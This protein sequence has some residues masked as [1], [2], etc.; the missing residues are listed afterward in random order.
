MNPLNVETIPTPPSYHRWYEAVSVL[1]Q[2]SILMVRH[3]HFSQ[4]C[5]P[6]FMVASASPLLFS[7]WQ[8]PRVFG[9]Y[10][11]HSPTIGIYSQ[12]Y[13]YIYTYIC[14]SFPIIFCFIPIYCFSPLCDCIFYISTIDS[15]CIL[16][17][18]CNIASHDI[19]PS[20]YMAIFY[21]MLPINR[22]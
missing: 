4:E 7:S 8:F 21:Y 11:S 1:D 13:V 6:I 2:D 16:D 18:P 19:D 3:A 17:N 14:I 22:L 20:L 10:S 12:G 15:H 5:S 9:M